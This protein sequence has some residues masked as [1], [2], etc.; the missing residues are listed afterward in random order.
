[1][2]LLLF[3]LTSRLPSWHPLAACCINCGSIVTTSQLA[4]CMSL[5]FKLHLAWNISS[6]SALSTVTLLQEIYCWNHPQRCVE[7]NNCNQNIQAQA[8]TQSSVHSQSRI[9]LTLLSFYAENRFNVLCQVHTT[10][11]AGGHYFALQYFK[12]QPYSGEQQICNIICLRTCI[13][14][15]LALRKPRVT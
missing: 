14:C 7:Q 1:M 15:C 12:T 3:F 2:L 13:S 5:H 9:Y 8:I 4:S 10:V 6:Q 11:H